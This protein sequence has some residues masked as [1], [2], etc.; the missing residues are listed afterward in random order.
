MVGMS[1][2]STATPGRLKA[3]EAALARGAPLGVAAASAGVSRR[4]V[5]RWLAEGYVT[6]RSLSAVPD[7]GGPDVASGDPEDEAIQRALLGTVMGAAREDWRAA[8]WLLRTRWPSRYG[9]RDG[10]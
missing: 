10:R 5:S 2:P 3:I 1:R 8:A 4:T 7:P 6:R 9:R